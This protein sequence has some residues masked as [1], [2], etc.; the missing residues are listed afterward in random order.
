M[1]PSILIIQLFVLI[2]YINAQNT[3]M[4]G[5]CKSLVEP[6]GYICEEHTVITQDGYILSLQRIP[7]ARS[8]QSA[9]KPPVLLQHGVMVVSFHGFTWFCMVLFYP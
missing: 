9:D 3:S 2:K 1:N 7:N 6:V 8:G 5:I 4:S